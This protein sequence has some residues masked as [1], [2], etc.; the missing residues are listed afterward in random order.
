MTD[1]EVRADIKTV[2]VN[3]E[4]AYLETAAVV[5]DEQ[6]SNILYMGWRFTFWQPVSGCLSNTL[7]QTK[8]QMLAVSFY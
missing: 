3:A 4:F 5:A 8:Q 2:F 7:Q 1:D 6:H